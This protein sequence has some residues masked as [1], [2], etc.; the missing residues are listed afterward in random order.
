MADSRTH[1]PSN[2]LETVRTQLVRHVPPGSR[3]TLGLSGGVDSVVLLDLLAR[4]AA[5]HPFRLCAIH[6]NHQISPHAKDWVDACRTL[7]TAHH[8]PLQVHTIRI[9]DAATLGLEAAA[10][11]AR[12]AAYARLDTD[13]VALAHHRDDQAETLLLQL[14]RGAGVKGLA[15]MPVLREAGSHPAYLRPLLDIDR[16]VIETWAR[17]HALQWVEDESNQDTH[18]NRNFLRRTVLP[19][20]GG[21]FPAWRASLARSAQNLA[22][23]A[24]LLDQLAALDATDAIQP[25]RLDCARLAALPPPRAR[26][27]LRHFLALNHIPMPSQARLAAMLG[28]L[29]HAGADSQPC[30]RHANWELHRYQG[31]AH[32]AA[33]LPSPDPGLHWHWQGEAQ[34][35]LDQLGASLGFTH[36]TGQGLDRA[37]LGHAPVTIRLRQ[38]GERFR[39]DCRRPRRSLKNLLQ[40]SAIPPWQR[41]RLPLLYCGAT[42][43][44]VAAIGVD[45]AW[46]APA[47]AAGIQPEWDNNAC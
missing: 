26:N 22:E 45:C 9:E 21:R 31:W 28:Q 40:E 4:L 43:V 3:I 35:A 20:L 34:L 27:L 29:T 10:R 7:C 25:Q 5:D 37:K 30:I 33:R 42:L 13:F 24:D 32:L 36:V 8:I 41:D 18:F 16:S 14:L 12:Y 39:P 17:Q 23:A 46:Q 38:G 11:R 19:L 1:Q 2:L 47:G 6:V 44:W 15:A